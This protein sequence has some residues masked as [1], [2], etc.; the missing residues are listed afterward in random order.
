MGQFLKHDIIIII[1]NIV[2]L[3]KKIFEIC[4]PSSIFMLT[5]YRTGPTPTI[6]TES[7]S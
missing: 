5:T 1:K 4:S 7:L 6:L 3:K 2:S